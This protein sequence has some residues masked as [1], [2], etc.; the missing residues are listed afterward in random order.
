MSRRFEVQLRI[1]MRTADLRWRDGAEQHDADA[2][3]DAFEAEWAPSRDYETYGEW[4][5]SA[6]NNMGEGETEEAFA[7]RLQAAVWERLQRFISME[8]V[9]LYVDD[10][11]RDVFP[12]TREAFEAWRA[13]CAPTADR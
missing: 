2:I 6:R 10:P 8:V 9:M 13:T 5:L 11:P 1:P 12:A 3:R 4:V 7:R